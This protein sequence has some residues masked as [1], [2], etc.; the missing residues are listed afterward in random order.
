MKI[1]QK[2]S[3]IF[4]LFTLKKNEAIYTCIQNDIPLTNEN[5]KEVIEILKQ[6]EY[7]QVLENYKLKT[8]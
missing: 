6:K 4:K 5:I 7:K 8:N 3:N 2:I 1:L